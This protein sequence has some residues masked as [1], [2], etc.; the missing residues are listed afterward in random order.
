MKNYMNVVLG[1][2]LLFAVSGCGNHHKLGNVISFGISAEYP[3][4][5]YI[6]KGVLKG[7]DIDLARLVAKQLNK[8]AVFENMQFSTIL[9][10]TQSGHVDAAIS[11]ITITPEREKNFDFSDSYYI[12]SLAMVYPNGAPIIHE[13][14]LSGKKIACQLGTTMEVWLKEHAPDTQII[15]FDGNPQAIEALKA[16]HVDGVFIDGIQATVFSKNNLGLAYAVLAQSDTGYGVAVK[17]GSPLKDEINAALKALEN[18]GELAALKK[19]CFV[20]GQ[21]TS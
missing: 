9:P 19:K 16:G 5:E 3:P 15:T 8:K 17:K 2:A 14:Q 4:F 10:A 20:E 12:E 6:Q 18:S 7:F 21:W 11:T 13:S 1:V